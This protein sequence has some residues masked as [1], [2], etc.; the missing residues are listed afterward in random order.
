MRRKA[1]VLNGGKWANAAVR[2]VLTRTLTILFVVS[3]LQAGTLETR[4]V[5]AISP[6]RA[7]AAGLIAIGTIRRVAPPGLRAT[8]RRAINVSFLT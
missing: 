5:A 6:E 2:S 8:A 3:L 7:Y 1:H 4:S